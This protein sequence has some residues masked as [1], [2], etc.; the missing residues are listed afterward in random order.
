MSE[1]LRNW[2]E[3]ERELEICESELGLSWGCV[4]AI[5]VDACKEWDV[6]AAILGE[7]G[8]LSLNLRSL[9]LANGF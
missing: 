4:E 5:L 9:N 6:A 1:K 2:E 3:K 7:F 8:G